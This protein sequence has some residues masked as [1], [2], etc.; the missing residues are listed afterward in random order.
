MLV[1]R[2]AKTSLDLGVAIGADEDAL[3]GFLPYAF[4]SAGESAAAQSERLGGR[5]EMMELECPDALGIAALS[6]GTAELL[7]ERALDYLASLRHC[8]GAT[9]QAG[10]ATT[11]ADH[12]R[13]CRVPRADPRLLRPV[14]PGGALP[15]SGRGGRQVVDAQPVPHGRDAAVELSG[16][17]A[18]GEVGRD[19]FQQLLACN[20]ASAQVPEPVRGVKAVLP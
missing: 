1:A 4:D 2:N 14:L 17:L 16:D 13:G 9:F 5:V 15:P 3:P 11:P 7:D 20:P 6:A 18:N 10:L 19:Q 8:R 12:E